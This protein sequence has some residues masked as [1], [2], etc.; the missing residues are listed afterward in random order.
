MSTDPGALSR[1]EFIDAAMQPEFP[2]RMAYQIDREYDPEHP[3]GTFSQEAVDA[4]AEQFRVFVM[5]RLVAQM[6][7]TGRPPLHVRAM[8]DL[9]WTPDDPKDG[10]APYYHIDND[11][12][13]EPFDPSRRKWG[14]N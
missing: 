13:L 8:V 2:D 14:W 3:D 6:D 1:D 4:L 5:A 11:N 10:D 12:G 7:K 9:D